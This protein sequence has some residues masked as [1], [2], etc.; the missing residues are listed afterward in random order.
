[1]PGSRLRPQTTATNTYSDDVSFP[2]SIGSRIGIRT[3]SQVFA[4]RRRSRCHNPENQHQLNKHVPSIA[5][6]ICRHFFYLPTIMHF[7]FKRIYNTVVQKQ[8]IGIQLVEN[9]ANSK[10]TRYTYIREAKKHKTTSTSF[11]Q[12]SH[13]IRS[14]L[15][16][17]I[18]YVSLLKNTHLPIYK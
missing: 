11:R 16:L 7:N 5:D 13:V 9:K 18:H 14:H 4:S 10:P 6:L 8:I 1:V 3:V 15:Q 12:K 2:D 17:Y